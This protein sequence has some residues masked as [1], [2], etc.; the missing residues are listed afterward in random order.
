MQ[1][2]NFEVTG[3]V[4]NIKFRYTDNG[5]AIADVCISKK[6]PRAKGEEDVWM[7]IW[8]VIFGNAA[9]SFND[10][11]RKGDTANVT[12]KIEVEWFKDKTGKLIH[13]MV[14][15]GWE[16]QRVKY[17]EKVKDY[18]PAPM[19]EEERLSKPKEEPGAKPWD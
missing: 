5:T 16:S 12:G 10:N 14:L 3:L 1:H 2:N 9:E 17:D 7:P 8:I 19:T 11:I 13:R 18:V 6:N 15:K 4:S